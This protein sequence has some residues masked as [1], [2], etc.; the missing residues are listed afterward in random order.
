MEKNEKIIS[1]GGG[2]LLGTRR[3]VTGG[4][5]RPKCHATKP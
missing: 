3:Y 1:G 2:R 5:I 4:K